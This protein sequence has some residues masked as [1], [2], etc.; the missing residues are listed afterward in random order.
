MGQPGGD[1]LGIALG[2]LEAQTPDSGSGL[3]EE[4]VWLRDERFGGEVFGMSGAHREL[5]DGGVEVGLCRLIQD[6]RAVALPDSEN[7][8]CRLEPSPLFLGVEGMHAFVIEGEDQE[9]ESVAH[10]AR[11]PGPVE[12]LG[13]HL[14]DP[15]EVNAVRPEVRG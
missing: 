9:H 12:V 1:P 8:P 11:G 15:I 3:E 14:V 6:K 13:R 2:S 7:G 10:Q 4:L 5:P